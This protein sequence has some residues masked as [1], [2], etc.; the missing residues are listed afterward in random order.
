MV[1]QR[2]FFGEKP[3]QGIGGGRMNASPTILLWPKVSPGCLGGE[4][5]RYSNGT[6]VAK[7]LAWV[8]AGGG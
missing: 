8:L 3:R 4:D 7:S 5:K 2:Y 1:L 6:F